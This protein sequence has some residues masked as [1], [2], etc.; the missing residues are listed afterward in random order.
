MERIKTVYTSM[1]EMKSRYDKLINLF[2]SLVSINILLAGISFATTIFITNSIG[3]KQFGD[4]SYSLAVGGYSLTLGYCGLEYTL[5]RDLVQAPEALDRHVS[6]S[7][8]L[9]F[10]MLSLVFVWVFC[11]NIIALG[12]DRLR[13][14][15]VLIVLSEG[16]KALYLTQVFDAWRLMKRS[17]FYLLIE[18]LI[19]FICIWGMILFAR[20][21]LSLAFI[22]I[23]MAIST[24]IGIAL[25]YKWALRRLVLKFDRSAYLLAIDLL[26]RNIWIWI[27]VIATLSFGTLSKIVLKIISGSEKLGGYS[28]AW[29][30]VSVGSIFIAQVN[31]IGQ[32]MMGQIARDEF[33][34]RDRYRFIFKYA[35]FNLVAGAFVGMPAIYF[36]DKIL[37]LFR[38]E[39]IAVSNTLRIF[40]AYVILLGFGQVAMQYLISSHNEKIYSSIVIFTGG[41]SIVL[42]YF[43]IPRWGANGAAF[44][45]LCSHGTAIALYWVFTIRH[46]L[47]SDK[48]RFFRDLR[49]R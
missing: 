16:V 42:Y 1:I 39:Y 7:L 3:T 19:Y 11:L 45:V 38:P 31:R 22:S 40:G 28:V 43:F 5:V 36:P 18:R 20:K 12:D 17:A 27:A 2:L 25:Q 35:L 47:H 24:V 37:I 23:F 4:L 30:V 34:V 26:K 6:A 32:P 15:G 44:A 13:P 8:I 29:L 21:H 41:L 9:R 14:S 33:P 49:D 46:L 10:G 48:K